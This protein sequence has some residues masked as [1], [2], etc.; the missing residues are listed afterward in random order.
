MPPGTGP[1]R[2]AFRAVR[3]HRMQGSASGQSWPAEGVPSS[4]YS[5]NKSACERQ[6][7]EYETCVGL[8]LPDANL[9]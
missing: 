4:P 6:P 7:E 8:N 2:L 1:L 3:S 5:V 9:Y